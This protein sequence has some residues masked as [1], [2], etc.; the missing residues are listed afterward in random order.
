MK[1]FCNTCS[2]STGST[3]RARNI[4]LCSFNADCAVR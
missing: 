2:T 1:H 3:V 4:S